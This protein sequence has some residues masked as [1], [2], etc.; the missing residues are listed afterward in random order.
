MYA[1][2]RVC[3]KQYRVQENDVLTVSSLHGDAG[4]SVTLDEVLAIGGAEGAEPTFGSPTVAGAS[5]AASIIAQARGPKIDGFTY[6]AKKN[7]RRHF[8]HRQE[9]TKLRIGAITAG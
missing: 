6:K 7:I 5:V 8:G 2:V 4:A 3:G 9:I 1:I